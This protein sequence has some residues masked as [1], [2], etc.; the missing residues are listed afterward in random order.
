MYT[1]PQTE[2]DCSSFPNTTEIQYQR[3]FVAISTFFRDKFDFVIYRKFLE[4]EGIPLSGSP[5]P[6]ITAR[7]SSVS[8]AV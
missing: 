7:Q 5:Q 1:V 8:A 4:A 3:Y 6:R 2:P